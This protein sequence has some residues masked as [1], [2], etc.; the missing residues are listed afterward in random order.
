MRRLAIIVPV[1]LCFALGYQPVAKAQSSLQYVVFNVNGAAQDND[2]TG[3][4]V[5]SFNETTGIGTLSYTFDPGTSGTYFVDSFFDLEVSQP[6]FNEYGT[7]SGAAATGQTWEIGDSYAS[8]IYNDVEGASGTGALSDV[9]SLP[10]Q[11]SNYLGGSGGT[12]PCTAGASC[13]V[14]AAMAM[15]F[16]FTLS[17]TQEAVI[18]L[19][20]STT[21]PG[22]TGLVLDQTHPVDPANATES[23]VYFTGNE[24]TQA[25]VSGP[26][27]GVPEPS[28][29]LL[30]GAGLAGLCLLKTKLSA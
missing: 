15:G 27:T 29:L 18:T 22:G 24:V 26:P 4:N 6:F 3:V 21:N 7:A 20:F 1:V 13:N 8:N 5:S 12:A 9:N 2:F 19:D 17:S 28:T 11:T 14:D 16:E 23:D 25:A 10:G 30:L